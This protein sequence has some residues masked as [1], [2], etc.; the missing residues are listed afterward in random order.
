MT[1][2]L[3]FGSG[4]TCKNNLQQV[5]RMIHE[6]CIIDN[7]RFEVI[8]KW[9]L[10][11]SWGELTPLHHGIFAEAYEFARSLG[12]M[13]TASVFDS[14]SLRFL[15]TFRVPFVKIA[16]L[17]ALYPLAEDAQGVGYWPD[18][19]VMSYGNPEHFREVMKLTTQGLACVR[20][21]PASPT[22]YENVHSGLLHYGLSDHTTDFRLVKKYKPALWER[23][24]CLDDQTGPDTGP[25]AVR[26]GELRKLMETI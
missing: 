12:Y 18:S 25:F 6:L 17:P 21:Y 23:H 13:T 10:F 20:E 4:E 9:Q 22:V 14:S 15:R 7:R 8:I 26:P 11:E 1:I 3:D 24:F 2:I 19:L 5:H 16:C